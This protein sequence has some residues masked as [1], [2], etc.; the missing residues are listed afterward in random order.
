MSQTHR[1]EYHRAYYWR[2]VAKRREQARRHRAES[3]VR[4]WC[5]ELGIVYMKPGQS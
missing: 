3:R 2:T 4:R 5:A 1:R